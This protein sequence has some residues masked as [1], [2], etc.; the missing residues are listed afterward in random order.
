M[1]K[2]YDG[3]LTDKKVALEIKK[4]DESVSIAEAALMMG[5][6]QEFVRQGLQQKIFTFGEAVRM[7]NSKKY[8]YYI[9]RRKLIKYLEGE[10]K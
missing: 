5:A 10:S 9:N 8:T 1:P 3:F 7:H 2:K 4:L 6:S